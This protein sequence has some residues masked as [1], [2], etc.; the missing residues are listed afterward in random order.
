M[1]GT[2]V[3]ITKNVASTIKPHNFG[4]GD[5]LEIMSYPVVWFPT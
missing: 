5:A 2:G 4:T 3:T 1:M